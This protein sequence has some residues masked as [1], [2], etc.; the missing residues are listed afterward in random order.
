MEQAGSLVKMRNIKR[1]SV[2]GFKFAMS[3]EKPLS[4]FIETHIRVM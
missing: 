3:P 2:F 1:K 4:A